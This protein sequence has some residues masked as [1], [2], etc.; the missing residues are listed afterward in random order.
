MPRVWLA[1]HHEAEEV[2]RLLVGFRDHYKGDW[3]SENAFLAVVDK[4]MDDPKTEYLL[5]SV[6]EDG[7]AVAVCQLRF[8]LSVWTASEDCWLEDLFVEESA[9]GSGLGRAMVDAAIA[10]ARERGCR[11]VELDVDADNAPARSLYEAMGFS[12]KNGGA[13]FM[14]HR[15]WDNHPPERRPDGV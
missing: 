12:E 7:P 10:R 5:G 2:A 8:R 1:E 13:R 4:L 15:I 6:E 3:P 9:R 11:R 14:Q